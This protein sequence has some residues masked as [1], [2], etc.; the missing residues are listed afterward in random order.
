MKNFCKKCQLVRSNF[1][2]VYGCGFIPHSDNCAL[3]EAA[4]FGT[5]GNV[6]NCDTQPTI[7]DIFH[8]FYRAREIE[9]I[10]EHHPETLSALRNLRNAKH[11]WVGKEENDLRFA[12]DSYLRGDK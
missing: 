8:T 4:S 1:C 9:H 11:T 7:E 10:N 6:C 2:G 5:M 3:N 12:L